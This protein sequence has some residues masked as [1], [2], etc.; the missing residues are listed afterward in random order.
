MWCIPALDDEFIARMEE[1]LRLYE[2]PLDSAEPV[3]CLDEKPVQLLDDAREPQRARDGSLRRDYEYRRHGTAN[4]FCAVEPRAGRHM[5]KVTRKRAKVDFANVLRDIAGA[6]E[7]AR[8]IHLVVDNLST[9]SRRAVVETFGEE[10]GGA[11]WNRFVVHYTPKH[12]SWL[13]AAEIEIG[14]LSRQCLGSRRL[15]TRALLRKQVRAWVHDANR[16]GTKIHWTFT[17]RDARAKF[18]Y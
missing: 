11:L 14:L 1:L 10:E 2:K 4:I 15:R 7:R 5:A 9:H 3:V 13:N 8:R 16:R 18:R 17:V 6:Y 12:G